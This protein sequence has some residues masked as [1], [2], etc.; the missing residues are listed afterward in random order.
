MSCLDLGETLLFQK[1]WD[2]CWIYGKWSLCL[3]LSWCCPMNQIFGLFL[4]VFVPWEAQGNLM[5]G[6]CRFGHR[7]FGSLM[8][9]STSMYFGLLLFFCCIELAFEIFYILMR[10]FCRFRSGRDLFE[11]CGRMCFLFF[12][13]LWRI[14]L[15]GRRMI[16]FVWF[17]LENEFEGGICSFGL[18]DVR[19]NYLC[20]VWP[21][22]LRLFFGHY[23]L[24]WYF[25]HL[26]FY[27][28]IK[29]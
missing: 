16:D 4:F 10:G 26:N 24:K 8:S 2:S 22:I 3:G 14:A 9:I 6:G 27:L 18:M 19:L 12:D 17:V 1:S 15:V 28:E 5:S 25:A 29:Y 7:I 23:F 20:W 11:V 13:L 21:F